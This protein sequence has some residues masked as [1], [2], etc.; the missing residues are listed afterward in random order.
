MRS[1]EEMTFCPDRKNLDADESWKAL[2]RNDDVFSAERAPIGSDPNPQAVDEEA[3]QLLSAGFHA[4]KP[5]LPEKYRQIQSHD[6]QYWEGSLVDSFDRC[7]W[8]D[9]PP[10][11]PLQALLSREAQSLVAVCKV[12]SHFRKSRSVPTHA[13]ASHQR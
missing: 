6:A 2:E 9:A 5:V 12:Y 7:L 13:G 3:V 10:E 1:R 8:Q 4:P 11:V